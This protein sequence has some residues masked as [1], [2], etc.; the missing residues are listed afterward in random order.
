LVRLD[1][2]P[3]TEADVTVL[4][5]DGNE[6]AERWPWVVATVSTV[7]DNDPVVAPAPAVAEA[8]AGELT[9]VVRW[10]IPLRAIVLAAVRNDD[11]ALFTR[12]IVSCLSL[13]LACL[14]RNL[15]CGIVSAAMSDDTIWFESMPPAVKP[16]DD[17]DSDE[18]DDIVHTPS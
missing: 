15:S 3:S 2:T 12:P 8:V 18:V 6:S 17:D 14:A 5:A 16:S 10:L 4:V 13:M 7:N 9:E 1:D 11:R